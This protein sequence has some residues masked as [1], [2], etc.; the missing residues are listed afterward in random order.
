[1]IKRRWHRR[2]TP[3]GHWA[4]TTIFAA[5]GIFLAAVAG[6][7]E[8]PVWSKIAVVAVCALAAILTMPVTSQR[9]AAPHRAQTAFV[10]GDADGSAFRNIISN[11][12]H[13]IEG[14]ARDALFWHIVHWRRK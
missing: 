5:L 2:R 3:V 14:N 7:G 10:R 8:W 11:A 6:W 4:G 12:D 9:P 13:F 1:M